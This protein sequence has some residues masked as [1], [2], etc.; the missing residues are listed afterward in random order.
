MLNKVKNF[1]EN[2]DFKSFLDD[3]FGKVDFYYLDFIFD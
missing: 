3:V 2:I 1:V